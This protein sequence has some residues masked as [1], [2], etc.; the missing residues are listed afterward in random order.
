MGEYTPCRGNDATFWVL[1][2]FALTTLSVRISEWPCSDGDRGLCT[3]WPQCTGGDLSLPP[4]SPSKGLSCWREVCGD[5]PVLA[6]P[7]LIGWSPNKFL[8]F[9][10]CIFFFFKK[11]HEQ[12]A[13]LIWSPQNFFVVVVLKISAAFILSLQVSFL[14]NHQSSC[15]WLLKSAHVHFVLVQ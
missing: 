13:A 3:L 9:L 6:R 5:R 10:S 2:R 4:S 14:V 8:S 15:P 12:L 1:F 11:Y 7:W